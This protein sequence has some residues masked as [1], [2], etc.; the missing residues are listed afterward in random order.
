M[1]MMTDHTSN[2]ASYPWFSRPE[3]VAGGFLPP[4]PTISTYPR[5]DLASIISSSGSGG[6]TPP[7]VNTD[8]ESYQ[9]ELPYL[10]PRSVSGLGSEMRSSRNLTPPKR[11]PSSVW[12]TYSSPFHSPSDT[13]PSLN[14]LSYQTSTSIST[15][16]GTSNFIH[17]T[18]ADATMT[19]QAP[20]SCIIPVREGPVGGI[21]GMGMDMSGEGEL[22]RHKRNLSNWS[23]L[24]DRTAARPDSEVMPFENFI[25]SLN[26]AAMVEA[27][28][29]WARD[30]RSRIHKGKK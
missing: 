7:T 18:P 16:Y 14:S 8:L 13:N 9:F 10:T 17:F 12:S 5:F 4:L 21:T 11:T 20:V 25:C 27:E 24:T 29:Q 6:P 3:S 23:H 26:T 30:G 2:T 19:S 22:G 28:T 1:S 15:P